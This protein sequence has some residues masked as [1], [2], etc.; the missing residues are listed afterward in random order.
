MKAPLFSFRPGAAGPI[1]AV[2]R[3]DICGATAPVPQAILHLLASIGLAYPIRF[4]LWHLRLKSVSY[5]CARLEGLL[6]I[7]AS[8][9]FGAAPVPID[10]FPGEIGSLLVG[11]YEGT[12]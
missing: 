3:W 8:C 10:C 11:H 12:S 2:P 5:E 7:Q 9:I 4:L 6:V 1:T